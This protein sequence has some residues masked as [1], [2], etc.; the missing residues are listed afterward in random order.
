MKATKSSVENLQV[1][2]KLELVCLVGWCKSNDKKTIA[3]AQSESFLFALPFIAAAAA[4]TVFTLLHAPE[5]HD[6]SIIIYLQFQLV[7][8]FYFKTDPERHERA[9][10]SNKLS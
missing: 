9:L 3:I 7:R 5:V 1:T 4:V 8:K 6:S 10:V 2:E